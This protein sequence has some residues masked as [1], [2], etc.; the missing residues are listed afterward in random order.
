MFRQAIM[1]RM[2]ADTELDKALTEIGGVREVTPEAR[3]QAKAAAA[4][5]RKQQAAEL[6]E[7]RRYPTTIKA[8][9]K[10][11]LGSLG[12]RGEGHK[13]GPYLGENGTVVNAWLV[14][15]IAKHE[16]ASEASVAA[17]QAGPNQVTLFFITEVLEHALAGNQIRNRDYR[18][19]LGHALGFS[20]MDGPMLSA[21]AKHFEKSS[22]MQRELTHEAEYYQQG[23]SKQP[24]GTEQMAAN[25]TALMTTLGR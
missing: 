12:A 16:K 25:Y 18:R 9:A 23:S 3:R 22:A 15:A 19:L 4:A 14:S 10:N 5:G 8:D 17:R 21:L 2:Q 20:V 13:Q 11:M 7:L 24:A 1:N 6:V